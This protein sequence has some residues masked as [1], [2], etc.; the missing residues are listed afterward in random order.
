MLNIIV[1]LNDFLYLLKHLFYLVLKNKHIFA[2]GIHSSTNQKV[3]ANETNETILT[4]F[5]RVVALYY[6][7][8]ATGNFW[9]GD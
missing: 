9:Y 3:K 6:N 2:A 8:S 4:Q 5:P 7:V 1:T